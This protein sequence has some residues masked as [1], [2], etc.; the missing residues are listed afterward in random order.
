MNN[1]LKL[2]YGA[3]VLKATI[4]LLFLSCVAFSGYSVRAKSLLRN[5]SPLEITYLMMGIGFLAFLV[6]SLSNHTLNG[7]LGTLAAPLTN[8]T[9]LMSILYLGVLSSLITA[10]LFNFSLSK[11]EASKNSV[12]TNLSTVVSIAAGAI[13]LGKAITFHAV[14]GAALIITGVVGTNVWGAGES[15]LEL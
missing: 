13:F 10:Y 11:I 3:A 2:A 8:G 6:A 9:F 14:I 4:F 12:F 15:S 5:Y 7:T 1:Q